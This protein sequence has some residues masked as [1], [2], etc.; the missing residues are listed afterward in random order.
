[1]N[2]KKLTGIVL[3]FALSIIS[4]TTTTV[5][6]PLDNANQNVPKNPGAV[7]S[8]P[9]VN[10]NN[11]NS[12]SGQEAP[13]N[14]NTGSKTLFAVYLMGSDL[15][16]DVLEPKG[17]PDEETNGEIV[18]NGAGS[19]D[20][21][22]MTESLKAMTPE[23]RANLDVVV[24]FGGARKQGWKGI[25]YTNADCIIKDSEDNYFGNSDC[26][27]Q[28]T[29]EGDM[30][31]EQTLKNF[32]T[33]L[34]DNFPAPDYKNRTLVLWDHGAAHIGYGP[35]TNTQTTMSLESISNAIKADPV[36]Y[37]MI[38]FDA[39][40]MGSLDVAKFVKNNAN[41][42]LASEELEPGHGWQYTEVF[43]HIANN[44]NA[45]VADIGKYMVDSFIDSPS[46]A[47]TDGRTLS[48]VDLREFNNVINA[49]AS[50]SGSLNASLDT[51]YPTVLKSA[52]NSQLYGK[53]SKGDLAY[54]F[55][56]KH[57]LSLLSANNSN[58]DVS[59]LNLALDKYILK[60]RND[61]TRKDS[62]GVAIF[63]INNKKHVTENFYNNSVAATNN[64]FD[65]VNKYITKGT[66]DDSSPSI[67]KTNST[68]EQNMTTQNYKFS[69]KADSCSDGTCFKITDN[70]GVRDVSIIKAM[71]LSDKKFIVLGS[72]KAPVLSKNVYKL[73]SWNGD[74][75]MLD[76]NMVPLDFEQLDSKGNKIY[77][78][79]AKYNGEE[80]TISFIINSA[81]QVIDNWVVPA[82]KVNGQV[83]F[84]REQ[85]TLKPGDKVQFYSNI[86][87][88]ESDNDDNWELGNIITIT[89]NNYSFGKAK[90]TLFSFLLAEDM[91]G[92]VQNS[93]PVVIN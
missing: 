73:A 80:A 54:S 41:Y 76:G 84:S 14:K 30:G 42:M 58:L 2:K 48:L 11:N 57:F 64:W 36:K 33:Y 17:T 92:N 93:D 86:I 46:H 31:K 90:G 71:S 9:V 78:V 3:S 15:E 53:E 29:P 8:S 4:C 63:D 7:N 34:K 82:D 69:A 49:I 26:Y 79:D 74:V 65:F 87:D 59:D 68:E 12:G 21:R 75:L 91:K 52:E 19:D 60:S 16:D 51:I 47:T 62:N 72:D 77:I 50:V 28:N 37:D 44:P 67:E 66:N 20:L 43:N 6:N 55:D 10:T 61:G 1:M 5:V 38:G 70:L 39:C 25:K 22:E 23:Q 45:S 88:T 13:Q 40:L 83:R 89:G 35:D 27:S 18:T 32:V 56:L 81:N 24:G 85:Y